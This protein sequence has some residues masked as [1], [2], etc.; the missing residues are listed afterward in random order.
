MLSMAVVRS[1]WQRSQVKLLPQPAEGV[2]ARQTIPVEDGL[3][4]TSLRL[5]ICGCDKRRRM[6]T[7]RSTRL[8]FSALFNTSG[9]RFRATC[10]REV[11]VA[12][13]VQLLY[14]AL[15]H[16][17]PWKRLISTPA[18][19]ASLAAKALHRH[20]CLHACI[21]HLPSVPCALMLLWRAAAAAA[22]STT[23]C[24]WCVHMHMRQPLVVRLC[25]EDC[26][27]PN[28]TLA[29][30]PSPSPPCHCPVLPQHC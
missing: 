3:R 25:L 21:A 10:S 17:C 11:G 13:L 15:L 8:A 16:A 27:A 29:L 26:R 6:H 20:N 18:A 7:S 24:A 28:Q 1:S 22:A 23:P 2:W 5:M 4:N 9:M 12:G 19:A 30:Y 14:G